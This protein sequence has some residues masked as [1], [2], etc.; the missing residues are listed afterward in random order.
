MSTSAAVYSPINYVGL[1]RRPILESSF[2]QFRDHLDE[3]SSAYLEEPAIHIVSEIALDY[4][5][6]EWP[7]LRSADSLPDVS[8]G[9][10][11]RV[12][13]RITGRGDICAQYRR[14]SM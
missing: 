6:V 2:P 11:Y 10:L 7:R 9:V 13:S 5:V 1:K 3:Y 4:V 12:G 8:P 14:N